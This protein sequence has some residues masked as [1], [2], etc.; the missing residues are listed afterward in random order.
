M[1]ASIEAMLRRI[2]NLKA[3]TYFNGLQLDLRDLRAG[4]PSNVVYEGAWTDSW[5][6]R[7]CLHRHGTIAQAA[8]CAFPEGP[9]WYVFAVENGKP[10]E[11][12]ETEER[13]LEEFRC[14]RWPLKSAHRTI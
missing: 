6:H 2:F 5:C 14:A 13:T 8:E 10:R 3:A 11:L 9:A 1:C 12:N 7:R 4:V